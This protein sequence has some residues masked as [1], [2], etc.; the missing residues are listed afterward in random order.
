MDWSQRIPKQ[1][2]ATKLKSKKKSRQQMKRKNPKNPIFALYHFLKQKKRSGPNPIK[3][4]QYILCILQC[5]ASAF[6]TYK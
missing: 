3:L 2:V 5:Y 6:V 4:T 1:H